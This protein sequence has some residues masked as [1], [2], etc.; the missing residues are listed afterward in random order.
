[1]ATL[2]WGDVVIVGAVAFVGFTLLSYWV[3][4]WMARRNI[5]GQVKASPPKKAGKAGETAPSEAGKA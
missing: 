2:T 4:A 5:S 1:M 3:S